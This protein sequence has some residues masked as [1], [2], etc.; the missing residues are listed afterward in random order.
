MDIVK[1]SIGL[2]KTIK[3][4]AR[5]REILST[6]ARNGFDE[7]INQSKLHKFIPG[8]MLPKSRF[9][10]DGESETKEFWHSVG[11]RLRKSFEELGPSFIKVGQLLSTREDLFDPAMIAELK[12]LQDSV[13]PIDFAIAKSV[14]EQNFGGNLDNVFTSIQEIPIGVASIGMAY[15]GKLKNGTNVVIK[16][17]RPG[18]KKIINSDFQIMAFIVGQLEKVSPEIRYL[19]ISRAIEDFFKSIQ[20]ELNYYIEANNCKTLK[21]NLEKL[22]TAKI[23]KIPEIYDEYVTEE[24]LVMEFLE[25]KP[26]NQITSLAEIPGLEEKL[27]TSV[28]MFTHT[29]L[30]DGFFH[31]DLHGGNFFLLPDNNIGLIDF[32]LIGTLSKKN[33]TNLV[34]IL[35][36]LVTK[37]YENLVF[38]FLDVADYDSIPN[39]E[40]LVRDIQDNISPFLVLSVQQIDATELFRAIVKTLNKHQIYLPREWFIIFRALMTL[41]G[42][43]KSLGIDF[44][45]FEIIDSEVHG[46]MADLVNK[47]TIIEEAVWIGRDTVNSLRIIPRHIR[48]M[49]KELSR[50]KYALDINLKGIQKDIRSVAKG[51]FFAGFM[52]LS[53][54]LFFAGVFLIK[55]LTI[56]HVNDIPIIVWVFWS[57]STAVFLRA[58]ILLR[59]L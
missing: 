34:A 43:G 29:I 24:T 46:I 31:A 11:F 10:F 35:Y 40:V 3:N 17:R 50:K 32:G 45:I 36:A 37:N 12:K 19:G 9:H 52:L 59:S 42:V 16:V 14:M 21:K 20:L 57:I 7:F 38:E 30:A 26:F 28:K 8:F 22:D 33:R 47:D 2:T 13:K 48:W 6:F 23:L 49:L 41:D 55:D 18:I 56:L 44:N 53:S 39:H 51:L 1:T 58:S 27:I 5:F 4:V 15:K 25:G 54:C